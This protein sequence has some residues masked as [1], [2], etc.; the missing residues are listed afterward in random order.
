MSDADKPTAWFAAS[1]A[2]FEHPMFTGEFDRRSAWLWLIAKAAWKDHSVRTRGGMIELKR[3]E[4]LAASEHLAEVWGRSR[5]RCRYWLGQLLADGCLEKG[6]R[7]GQYANVYRISNYDRFQ[8]R[9]QS[10]GQR[11]GHRRASEGP[12]KGH[13]E[14]RRQGK[15]GK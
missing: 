6:Q 12:T 10:A 15:Q 14:Q 2:I 9:P 7:K 13:T 8:C 3:G 11:K 5:K 1:K 4:V